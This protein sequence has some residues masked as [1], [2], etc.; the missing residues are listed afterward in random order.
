MMDDRSVTIDPGHLY[1]LNFQLNHSLFSFV[2]GVYIL[3]LTLKLNE[4]IFDIITNNTIP[5]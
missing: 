3:I 2:D 5:E 4:R 1:F